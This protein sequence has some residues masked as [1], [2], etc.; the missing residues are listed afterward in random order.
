MLIWILLAA[1]LAF[2]AVVCLRAAAFRPKA[3]PW[4]EGDACPVDGDAAVDHLASMVRIPTVSNADVSKVDEAQFDAFR[5]LLARLYPRVH[6]N[7]TLTR[8]DRTELLYHWKGKA[9]IPPPC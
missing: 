6:A 4:G 3:S 5:A 7:L 2:L 9:P 8:T 1:L